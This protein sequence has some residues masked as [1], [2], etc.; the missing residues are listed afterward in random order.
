MIK[1][2]LAAFLSILMVAG[3]LPAPTLAAEPTLKVS[4]TAENL[5]DDYISEVTMTFPSAVYSNPMDIVFVLDGSTSSDQSGLAEQAAAMLTE[6][7]AVQGLEINAGLVIFGGEVPILYESDSLVDLSDS[8]KLQ[9]L[10]TA[11][12]DKSYDGV[13][14]RSGS[15]LQAGIEKARE[16]LETG[17]AESEGK[18]MILLTDGGARM[19]YEDGESVAKR[20]GG[21]TAVYFNTNQDFTDRY[22][23]NG[24]WQQTRPFSEVIN[25][26]KETVSRFSIKYSEISTSTI[27][28]DGH[29]SDEDYYTNLEAATYFAAK[30]LEEVK[31]NSEANVIWVDYPYNAGSG[32]GDYTES[33]KSWLS[34]NKYITRYDSDS[35]PDPFAQVKDQ[36]IYY[37][38][39]GSVVENVIGYGTDNDGNAYDFK[40]VNLDQMTLKVGN[41]EYTAIYMEDNK[42]G[43]GTPDGS[44]KYPFELT[45]YP[46]TDSTDERF[47]LAINTSVAATD[48]VSLIYQVQLTNPQ[49]DGGTY[50]VYDRNGSQNKDS[51]KVSNRATLTPKSSSGTVGTLVEF[52]LPTVSY[53]TEKV[54]INIMPLTVYVGGD[55]YE[56]VVSNANGDVAGVKQNTLPE[57][58]YTIDLPK[59]V[60]KAL[61]EKLGVS[62]DTTLD[63]SGHLTF[64]YDDGAGTTREWKI[65]RYDQN[66]GNQSMVN[67][68]YLYRLVPTEENQPAVRIQFTSEDGNTIMTNDNFTIDQKNPNQTYTMTIHAGPLNQSLV[69]AEIS[70]LGRSFYIQQTSAQLKIRGVVSDEENPTTDIVNSEPEKPVTEMTAQVLADTKYYYK[71]S[72]DEAS[73]IQVADGSAVSLLVDEVLPSATTE[74]EQSA[75]NEFSDVLPDKYNIE[76]RYLDLVYT[77]NSN[78]VVA[79]TNPV[80]VYWPYPEGTNQNTEFFIVHYNGLNRN[81]DQALTDDYTMDLYSADN[82]DT[83]KLE[84]TEQGIKITVNS[85]S[86]FALIWA[87][88]DNYVPPVTPPNGDDTPDL[89]TTD[90]FSY[91]V[92]YP[93][94]YRTGEPTEDED[95]WPVKPQGNIT[96]A[97]VATI[98]YRLLKD[99]V[100]EENWTQSNDYTDVSADDWFNAPVST[101]GA[102]GIVVGYEDGSFRPNATITRAEFAAIAVRFFEEDSAIY[103]EGTFSDIA[104]SEWF[105]DA[106]QAAK[107]HG[108]IGGYPDGSFQPNEFISRAEACSIV[109]R[110]LDRIP[111]EDH[112]LPVAEMNNWPDNLEGAWYYADMQEATNGHEYEWITDDGKTV[113]DWTGELPEIDWDEVERELCELHGVPYKG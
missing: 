62:E 7:V 47:E 79:A 35:I 102:M 94:D 42:Y 86:P 39:N 53:S 40:M 82:Q 80:T 76:M 83:Y 67:G 70:E 55:G 37:V 45:Y 85:F 95:L 44:G 99:E 38:S 12:T 51:L 43:F 20:Y 107:D 22:K 57:P 60:D 103:E 19:W 4:Q 105:A 29:I 54:N 108:I 72:G 6:L 32:F 93:E 34:T 113:E 59:E 31:D 96:R 26:L 56:G 81:D 84:N 97:E 63:L 74:L 9:A 73:E 41:Q 106:V 68:R 71:T 52:P 15:N 64:T 61:K 91:I 11:M 49:K 89:N 69:K 50:G 101:L 88:E 100:R 36:L 66:E 104:G 28:A 1:R 5:N 111:H 13:T 17:R 18:Y 8:D 92:G 21:T 58:G 2:L 90:H 48:Q 3:L 10:T 87:D 24:S 65:E 33:F 23:I 25:A 112:L 98:F 30:S 14:G 46:K 75:V 78:A 27:T 77:K 16:L 110:T 109:N